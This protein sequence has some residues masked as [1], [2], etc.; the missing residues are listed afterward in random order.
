MSSS[1]SWA[2]S[3]VGDN[4]RD[5]FTDETDPVDRH[6]RSVRHYRA[7][8]YPVRLDV[9]DFASEV[10]AGESKVHTGGRPCCRQVHASDQSVRMRRTEDRQIKH[11]GQFYV[12]DIM[13]VA[14][15]EFKVLSSA[16][17][18]ADIRC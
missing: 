6:Y 16:E 8:Y 14:S 2:A 3:R 4:E 5:A 17:R 12:I 15:D 11:A 13:P 1:A 18:L 7:G 9:A 10:G